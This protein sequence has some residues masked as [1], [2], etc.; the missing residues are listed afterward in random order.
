MSRRNPRQSGIVRSL[1]WRQATLGFLLSA[2]SGILL[3]EN[4]DPDSLGLH[5]AWSENSGWVDAQPNGNG[6]QGL[7]AS[8][9]RI[10]GWLWS[11][12]VGWI[13]AHCS[14]TA[15]CSTSDFGL[16]LQTDQNNPAW[17]RV[18]GTAWSENAG[19]IVANC[20]QTDSC[21]QGNYGLRIEKA[22]GRIEGY[23]WSENLGW[24]NFSCLNTEYCNTVNFGV[25]F[26][27]NALLP[28]VFKDSFENL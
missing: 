15:S 3:A 10:A 11:A 17:F 2:C 20:L 24:L 28:G 26:N 14:N 19:W 12:N 8:D 25:Q 5:W 6:G 22:T 1:L 23:A 13:S 27:P 7:Q 9:T 18:L 4:V 21:A 16:T